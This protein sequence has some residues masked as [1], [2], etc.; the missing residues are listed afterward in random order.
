MIRCFP[1]CCEGGHRP[2]SFCGV[3]VT[4][5]IKF[6]HTAEIDWGKGEILFFG[7]FREAADT[8]YCKTD[9]SNLLA[10]SM[11][12]LLEQVI[13]IKDD[14]A[15]PHKHF[16]PVDTIVLKENVSDTTHETLLSLTVSPIGSYYYSWESCRWKANTKHIF[17]ICAFEDL[18]N[19]YVGLV[20]SFRSPNDNG[21][22]IRSSRLEFATRKL[23]KE[24]PSVEQSVCRND[25]QHLCPQPVKAPNLSSPAHSP[26]HQQC[27]N[28]IDEREEVNGEVDSEDFE[29][30]SI[31]KSTLDG[32]QIVYPHLS[33]VATE[34]RYKKSSSATMRAVRKPTLIKSAPVKP[35]SFLKTT[36]YAIAIHRM[37]WRRTSTAAAFQGL[38][39]AILSPDETLT[40][41]VD[42]QG[43]D[44]NFIGLDR[45]CG[46]SM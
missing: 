1:S 5:E 29:V 34:N 46:I 4:A 43:R 30:E 44:T 40:A 39:L 23:A 2:N 38:A 6:I 10:I 21:F 15:L 3:N 17:E 41:D 45:E 37:H 36:K 8:S 16:I 9:S 25:G 18:G 31:L 27:E 13:R 11:T 7:S 24:V 32:T 19:G 26:M 33:V 14:H 12:D 20:N 35:F 28:E 42:E 22:V